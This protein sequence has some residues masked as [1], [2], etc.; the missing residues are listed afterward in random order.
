MRADNEEFP[1]GIECPAH[2]KSSKLCLSPSRWDELISFADDCRL[3]VVFTLN[4]MAGRCGQPSCG[5]TGTGPWNSSNT[6]ALLAYT[7][8]K[9]PDFSQHGFELGNELEFNL[10]PAQTATAFTTLRAMVN[11]LWPTPAKRPRIVGARGIYHFR[12][13]HHALRAV[14]QTCMRTGCL[15][16]K[17]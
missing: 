9:H 12:D 10:G 5:H 13:G 16:A 6:H 3:R 7:A 4:M 8:K 1:G 17:T 11:E 14:P 15:P 2:V